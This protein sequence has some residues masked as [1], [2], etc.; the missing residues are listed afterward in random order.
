QAEAEKLDAEFLELTE[1][2]SNPDAR[3]VVID[4]ELVETAKLFK[5]SEFDRRTVL[6]FDATPVAASLDEDG[7]RER[8]VNTSWRLDDRGVFSDSHGELLTSGLGWAV[9]T[10][11]RVKFTNGGG[12]PFKTRDIPVAPDITGLL[13]S[14]VMAEGS[15]L[16]LVTRRGKVLRIDPAAVNPQGAAGNGVAG[17]KLAADDDQVIAALPLTCQNGEAILSLSEKAW[18]VTEV[19][20][21]PVKGRGGAGVGFHPFTKGEDALLSASV[22]ATGFVRGNRTVR[23]ENRA[24]A[25]I[26]G[27]GGAE[28]TPAE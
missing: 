22:S 28:V 21:I 23:A 16:A 27:S 8:K 5:G 12:L 17:V 18:K 3:R 25:S 9:W 7:P 13:R 19:A 24:K 10:D 2:V 11:G 26:K 6:D 15:H 20:D 1:L 14:G 4:A